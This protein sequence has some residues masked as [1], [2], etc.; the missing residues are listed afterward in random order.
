VR[1]LGALKIPLGTNEVE[2]VLRGVAVPR[3]NHFRSRSERA[4][5]SRRSSSC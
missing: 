5:E 2:Q 3:K 1:C 4:P